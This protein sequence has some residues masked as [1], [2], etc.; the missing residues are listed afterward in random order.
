MK[1]MFP[2]SELFVHL[3]AFLW[4]IQTFSAYFPI[5]RHVDRY[6][7]PVRAIFAEYQ[8]YGNVV[9]WLIISS[10]NGLLLIWHQAITGTIEHAFKWFF[11]K[12]KHKNIRP[13]NVAERAVYKM[14]AILSSAQWVTH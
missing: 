5:A 11:K 8:S 1:N 14:V 10:D 13:I 12:S 3:S 2:F 6:V 9:S 4:L 7:R